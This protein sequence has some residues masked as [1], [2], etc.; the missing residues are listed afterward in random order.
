MRAIAAFVDSQVP[1]FVEVSEPAPPGEEQVLC[2]TIQL[3]VCG[4][5]REILLSRQ[6]WVPDGESFIALGHECLAQVE[7]VGRGVASLQPGQLVVPVVRRP[8]NLGKTPFRVDMLSF[9]EFTERGIIYEHGFSLP[10]WLDRPEYLIP[11]SEELREVAV[12]TEPLA[13]AEKGINEA[14]I[15]QQAR[16]GADAWVVHPPRVLVT[17]LGPIA[18]AALIGCYCRHWPVTVYGRDPIETYRASLARDFGAKYVSADVFSTPQDVETNGFDLILECTG[19]A[20]V[21]ML[22]AN[23]LASRG[24]MVWLG[25]TRLPQP[26][27]HNFELMMRNAI[28]RNHVHFGT[29]NA[30]LRDFEFALEHLAQIQA[31]HPTLL[32]RIITARVSP[33]DALWHYQHRE[34][35]GIKTVVTYPVP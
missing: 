32:E 28:L 23:S 33:N 18:F 22:T 10:V 6:P 16:L 21:T 24:A 27:M 7:A 5:D 20:Q 14:L 4:T 11:V 35:Q 17:G 25:S 34:P 15:I 26:E 30:A 2:R 9:G 1:R 12:F 31:K 13:V 29:V 3:G 19:S 8:L